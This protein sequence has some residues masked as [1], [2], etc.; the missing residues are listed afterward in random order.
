MY[1]VCSAARMNRKD[2]TQPT[3]NV[4]DLCNGVRS[5]EDEKEEDKER[6]REDGNKG[7]R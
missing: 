6:K 4:S 2:S 3:T 1:S 5:I 7:E